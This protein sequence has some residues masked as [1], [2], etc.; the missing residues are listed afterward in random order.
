MFELSLNS[1][2]ICEKAGRIP[3]PYDSIANKETGTHKLFIIRRTLMTVKDRDFGERVS[4]CIATLLADDP[5]QVTLGIVI[6]SGALGT[7]LIGR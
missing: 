5:L 3:V 4:I 7:N 1:P 6:S 2:G